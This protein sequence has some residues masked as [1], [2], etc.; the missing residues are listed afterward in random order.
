MRKVQ[1]EYVYQKHQHILCNSIF[2]FYVSEL[3]FS[4]KYQKNNY[5]TNFFQLLDNEDS[6]SSCILHATE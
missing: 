2:D 4:L 5:I 1:K 3:S 6:L